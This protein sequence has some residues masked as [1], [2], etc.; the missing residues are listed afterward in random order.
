MV[1]SL[2]PKIQSSCSPNSQNRAVR[3]TAMATRQVK[4][5]PMICSA[6]S[7]SP[8]PMAMA[9]LGAPP[10]AISMV[11]APMRYTTGKQRPMPVRAS[12]P[13]WGIWPI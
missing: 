5:P 2:H 1:S 3:A 13:T 9:A 8:S 10:W 4:Q 7:L 6:R 11:N 12:A